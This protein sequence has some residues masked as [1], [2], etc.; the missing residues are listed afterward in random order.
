VLADNQMGGY[1]ATRY[2]VQLGHRRIACIT[3]PSETA[4]S[5][6]RLVGYRRALEEASIPFEDKLIVRG[7]FRYQS[8]ELGMRTLLQVDPRPTAVFVCNDMMALGV[9]KVAHNLGIKIPEDFS[10][11]GFD[12]IPLTEA[13]SPSLTS[14]SQPYAKMATAATELLLK[15]LAGLKRKGIA[16]EYE[17]I[18]FEPTLSV[19]ES[20]A[21][22]KE[23]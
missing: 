7:D 16:K 2:L 6:Q 8:G 4:P 20:C 15:R 10:V 14:V 21:P 9:I 5:M 3:G 17:R 23:L 19:R 1:L 11:V 12:D 22:P 18:V 13:V